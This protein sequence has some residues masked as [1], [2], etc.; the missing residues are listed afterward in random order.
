MCE[1]Q[2]ERYGE[3]S[4]PDPNGRF[5]VGT[6]LF[7]STFRCLLLLLRLWYRVYRVHN[8]SG[9]LIAQAGLDRGHAVLPPAE[10]GP[11]LREWGVGRLHGS[12]AY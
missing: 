7:S 1:E 11:S 4:F 12:R 8:N 2:Q 6:G 3:K 9:L 10:P 5:N